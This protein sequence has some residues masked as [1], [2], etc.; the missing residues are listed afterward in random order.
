MA[1]VDRNSS[2][3]GGSAAQNGEAKRFGWK[4]VSL[5]LGAVLA[6]PG[7]WVLATQTFRPGISLSSASA[8]FENFHKQVIDPVERRTVWDDLV[9]DNYRKYGGFNSSYRKFSGF[10][11]S[12]N[13]PAI[14]HI[15]KDGEST[16]AVSLVFYPKG[17]NPDILHP[18]RFAAVFVC[19]D[20]RA[21]WTF[22]DCDSLRLDDIK[23][24]DYRVVEG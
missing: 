20:W 10:W 7:A 8:Y 6:I 5:I 12:Q 4:V 24:Y 13:R 16:F 23:H 15:S 18:S 19:D 21:R 9:T 17:E 22:G 2:Q 14:T 11:G 1:D 3:R